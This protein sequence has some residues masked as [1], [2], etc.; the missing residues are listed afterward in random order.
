MIKYK[1]HIMKIFSSCN[2]ILKNCA[3]A[4]S[5]FHKNK[6][7]LLV[8]VV[9]LIFI[10]AI[11][12]TP[13]KILVL[14]SYHQGYS[15]SDGIIDGI[16]ATFEKNNI[17]AD[18]FIEYM[19]T[20]RNF[21]KGYY[22]KLTDLYRNKYKNNK[23][24][25]IISCDDNAFQFLLKNKQEIFP[26]TPIIFC[27]VNNLKTSDL[28]GQNLITG[29]AEGV[30]FEENIKLTKTLHPNSKR[31]IVI[32][33]TT[34]SVN[35]TKNKLKEITSKY[36]DD[37]EFSFLS[38]L[39]I[40]QYKEELSKT[41]P[42]DIIYHLGIYRDSNGK[43]FNVEKSNKITI[44][45]CPSPVY[46][47]W[48]NQFTNGVLGG[49]MACNFQQG[50]TAAQI[51]NQIL[52]GTDPS[53]I[54]VLAGSNNLY[55]FDYQK[56]KKFKINP[57]LLPANSIIINNPSA[58]YPIK[59]KFL[60]GILAG[61]LFLSSLTFTL[62]IN[63][64]KRKKAEK[65]LIL[66]DSAIATS[67]E[68]ILLSDLDGNI[69]YANNAFYKIRGY[70]SPT[71]NPSPENHNLFNLLENAEKLKLAL[72][73][74]NSWVGESTIIKKDG[75]KLFVQVATHI[76]KNKKNKAISIMAS[77]VNITEL[78]KLKNKLFQSQKMEA[79]G[80][81]A[82]GI[83]HDFNNLLTIITGY[84]DHLYSQLQDKALK[85][86]V[87]QIKEAS[88]LASAVTKQL[89]TFSRKQTNEPEVIEVN[90]IINNTGILLARLFSKDIELK[91]NLANKLT[92]IKID[93]I[94]LKQI[95]LNL[96]LNANDAM[97]SGGEL[98]IKT[99]NVDSDSVPFKNS[100]DV[101]SF[102]KITIKDTGEG[103]DK[104]TLIHIFEPFF[105]TK[106]KG[107]G[108]GLGLATV[109]GLVKQNQGYIYA[110]SNPNQGTVFIIYFPTTLEK[111]KITELEGD[112]DI[113]LT[114]K[115][116][117]LLVED[118]DMIRHFLKTILIKNE[119]TVFE[120]KNGNEALD[121]YKEQEN[122][123]DLVLTDYSIPGINGKQLS[124]QIILKNPDINILM[125]S[126]LNDEEYSDLKNN[127]I[128]F[129]QK[130][131]KS[132]ELLTKIRSSLDSNKK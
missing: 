35:L 34:Y 1:V 107:K 115:E 54:P 15:W 38:D 18:L 79:I 87:S 11:S 85:N 104:E 91:T 76:V 114:G 102:V 55:M 9:S 12:A 84:S 93:P 59:K 29:V 68:A 20:K 127:K 126:G 103:M 24:Q 125:I 10:N 28:K 72:S 116:T 3:K 7:Q 108:T 78:K 65:D 71:N 124:K 61:L 22:A 47:F 74:K 113:N 70:Q 31:I 26:N 81:L 52:S 90:K 99:E 37:I 5:I 117:I 64:L 111:F 60:W 23:F 83:A 57:K 86:E 132:K 119:Y 44:S 48:N 25:A 131:F 2:Y 120:A 92:N 33:D 98:Y 101:N 121:L 118:E 53:N 46:T 19:D 50:I 21:Q 43:I 95:I 8:I 49:Y 32:G 13:N 109:Y 123:I 77:F 66:K 122:K 39:S 51:T 94:H 36:S 42:T 106:E 41:K 130:P 17:K 80:R 100:K 27:G 89:L 58:F 110:K 69:T 75:T 63:I 40:D 16:K 128:Q 6:V 97:S 30:D 4:G 112:S 105:T 45:T 82:G 14:N 56:L 96:A 67:T 88:H 129:L 73:I 62:I